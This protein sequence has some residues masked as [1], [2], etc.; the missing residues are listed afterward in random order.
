[1]R[2]TSGWER[3]PVIVVTAYNFE[4]AVDVVRAGVDEFLIKSFDVSDVLT[5][6]TRTL[7]NTGGR[8]PYPASG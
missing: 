2:R 8:G 4:E 7:Q 3:A 6:V 1:M 5:A